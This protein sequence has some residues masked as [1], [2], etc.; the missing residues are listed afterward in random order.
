MTRRLCGTAVALLLLALAPAVWSQQYFLYSPK[1]ASPEDKVQAKDG[2]L[3]REV[4]VQRGDTLSGLSRKFSGHG[5]Y[6]SQILLFNDIKDP[7]LIYAGKTLRVPV[8]KEQV[9]EKV[10]AVPVLRKK[11]TA[12]PVAAAGK[13]QA[14]APVPVARRPVAGKAAAAEPL[15]EISTSELRR[16]D[17]PKQ[18]KREVRQPATA[19]VRKAAPPQVIVTVKE[20]Q[21][22]AAS[23]EAVS[24]QKLFERALR[25][26]R[27]DD[28]RTALDL[29][30]RFLSDN[31]TSPLAADASLYKAECY[32]KLS[33]Q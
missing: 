18:K 19:A 26:Y 32:L 31:P 10:S 28:C 33:S 3:V 16:I 20:K 11:K 13:V 1:T 21:R 27:Q 22:P 4:P 23:V 12:H 17:A 29:F 15:T 8:S 25:S 2:V 5:S 9:H 24:G 6:Y 7:N 30:E 14:V